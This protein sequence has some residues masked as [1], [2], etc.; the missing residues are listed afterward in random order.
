MT[1]TRVA[2]GRAS[3]ATVTALALALTP[4][5]SLFSAPVQAPTVTVTPN[6]VT[7]GAATDR[8]WPRAYSTPSGARLL[9]YQPQVSSWADH[10]RPC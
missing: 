4:T 3:V 8:G 5:A 6:P 10:R 7:T 9:V 1:G 2:G